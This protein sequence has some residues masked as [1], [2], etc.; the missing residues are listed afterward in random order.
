[1]SAPATR[2]S[3]AAEAAAKFA[4]LETVALDDRCSPL[5]VRIIHVMSALANSDRTAWPSYDTLEFITGAAKQNVRGAVERLWNLGYIA[6]IEKDGRPGR[7]KVNRYKLKEVADTQP[8]WTLYEAWRDHKEACQHAPFL[9]QKE[10]CQRAKEA[11]RRA[12]T[13]M[14]ACPEP[15]KRSPDVEDGSETTVS[16]AARAPAQGH[17]EGGCPLPTG[18]P[19]DQDM[20][21]ADCWADFAGIAV[22]LRAERRAFRSHHYRTRSLLTDW[23]KAWEEWIDAA[24]ARGTSAS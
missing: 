22:D 4:L 18:F 14:L 20:E 1:M 15:L 21:N 5:M 17:D 3:K 10:A 24:I 11:S 9:T 12:R 16:A 13:G 2:P 8:V 7:S 19:H 23:P 6:T